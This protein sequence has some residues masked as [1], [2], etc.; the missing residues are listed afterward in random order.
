[1]IIII[2]I[3]M[4]FLYKQAHIP[5]GKFIILITQRPANGSPLNSWTHSV[6]GLQ[7]RRVLANQSPE[8]T[9]KR[10]PT[11]GPSFIFSSKAWES[12]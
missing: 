8:Q 2:Q 3:E 9:W 7:T 1:M 10:L 4:C 12:K 5:I 11:S 6:T